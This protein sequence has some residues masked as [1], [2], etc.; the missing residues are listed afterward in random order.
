MADQFESFNRLAEDVQRYPM[1]ASPELKDRFREIDRLLHL[2][3]RTLL[4]TTHFVEDNLCYRLAEIAT[5]QLKS[6]IYRGRYVK[7]RRKVGHGVEVG[8]ENSKILGTGF[9]LFKLSRVSRELAPPLVL[10]VLRNLRLQ[11]LTYEQILRAFTTTANEYQQTCEQLAM[12]QQQLQAAERDQQPTEELV[13]LMQ[14]ISTLIDKKQRVESRTG[15]ADTNMLYG[16]VALTSRYLQ[17]ID[18]VQNQIVQAYMRSIPRVVREYAQSDLDALDLFQAGSFGLL[19][20]VKVYD[21]RS[22]AGF[23]RVARQWIRERIRKSL[24][25]SS[26]PL[27]QLGPNVYEYAQKIRRARGELEQE[28]QG[29]VEPTREDIATRLGWP[30]EKVDQ[31]LE[32]MN[33]CQVVSLEDDHSSDQEYMERADV[34]ADD[35]EEELVELAQQRQ[36]VEEIIQHLPLVDQQ[37]ICLH[38]GCIDLI[39]NDDID[40]FQSL[41]ERLRQLA[42]KT[43]LH[44]FLAGRI[45]TRSMPAEPSSEEENGKS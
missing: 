24:R 2:G 22:R 9:D 13:P 21:Y 32:K 28:N 26:G 39:P 8:A 11:N 33:L 10:R 37:L 40:G 15:C 35:R 43:L 27:I 41:E 36:Y 5:G 19:H 7:S 14:D 42:C 25:K 31:I 44:E 6:K 45:D 20:A 1:L 12:A 4:S 38:Y 29:A 3:V 16:T 18:R 34:I 23:P 17:D 30:V